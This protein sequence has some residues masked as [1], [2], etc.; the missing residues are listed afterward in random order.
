MLP[1]PHRATPA[2]RALAQSL[3]RN[4]T[5]TEQA[6]WARLNHRQFLGLKFRRQHIALGYILDFY[7]PE[8]RL[9]IEL[10]GVRHDAT[11]DAERDLLFVRWHVTI[12][13][14]PAQKPLDEILKAMHATV[15]SL[16]LA[17]VKQAAYATGAIKAMDHDAAW[18]AA[19][20][21]ELQKQKAAI[22]LARE[23]RQLPLEMPSSVKKSAESI[24]A[25]SS[26]E[27]RQARAKGK[28]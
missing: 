28:R 6:L 14:F 21:I 8:Y 5:T 27:L 4:A 24:S 11:R 16:Q 13:R 22:Y 18:Y 2:L 15:C 25:Q 9:G 7:C 3:R 23:D 10:D 26:G 19:R 20:R 17:M 1:V 12:L